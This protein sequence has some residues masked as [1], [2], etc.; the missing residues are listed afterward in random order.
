DFVTTGDSVE[1]NVTA[2]STAEI[3]RAGLALNGR[4]VSA[5]LRPDGTPGSMTGRIAG[6]APGVNILRL[7]KKKGSQALVGELEVIRAVEPV[8]ACG[9][10]A[11]AALPDTVI[12]S[13]VLNADGA[14]SAAGVPLP[15]HCLVR[16][17]IEPRTGIPDNRAYGT[18]FELRVPTK[19]NG[20]F[21]FQ[22]QGGT[23]GSV[24]AAT[25]QSQ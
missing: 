12:T 1:I 7:Y 18:M 6:L 22:G 14:T 5:L 11:H 3:A 2:A 21:F 4:D 23:G 17:T 16:G 25:G 20:R 19:W 8:V 24:V 13:T 10:L 9:A 15:E